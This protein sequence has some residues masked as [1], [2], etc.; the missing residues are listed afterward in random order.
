MVLLSRCHDDVAYIHHGITQSLSWCCSAVAMASLRHHHGT[1]QALI[2][3]PLSRH[4]DITQ[5]S[6]VAIMAS[7]SMESPST[8]MTSHHG[9]TGVES[10]SRRCGVAQPSLL[11]SRSAVNMESLSITF[12]G[13]DNNNN[14]NNTTMLLLLFYWF[15]VSI[16]SSMMIRIIIRVIV[17]LLPNIK[18]KKNNICHLVTY[19]SL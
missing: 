4:H 12:V 9:I 10:L 2:M 18:Y 6:S 3:S 1:T 14:N 7:T 16:D 13:S 19:P 8:S 5:A 11:W 17:V 15:H